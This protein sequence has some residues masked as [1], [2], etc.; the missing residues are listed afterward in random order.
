VLRRKRKSDDGV[1]AV[2][3][4]DIA[5][6]EYA[7]K[8]DQGIWSLNG[9]DISDAATTVTIRA[10][11]TQQ[12]R[13]GTQ[14]LEAMKLVNSRSTTTPAELAAH[15]QIDSRV[16]GNLLARLADAAYI[17]KPSRGTYTRIGSDENDESDENDGQVTFPAS[18]L[19]DEID[20]AGSGRLAANSLHSSD[21]SPLGAPPGGVTGKTPGMTDRVQQ[22]LDHARQNGHPVEAASASANTR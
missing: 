8:T 11:A 15:L 12:S 14:S 4:R 20:G 9:M 6:N 21:S 19:G 17:A 13:L 5:E 2:T 7:I 18:S 1:L 22:A 10:E 3:G 16:A